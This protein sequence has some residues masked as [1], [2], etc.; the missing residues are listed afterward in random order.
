MISHDEGFAVLRER[1]A[2]A[3]S[4]WGDEA[5]ARAVA[6][7]AHPAEAGGTDLPVLAWLDD[8]LARAAEAV[9][10]DLAGALGAVARSV[11]WQQ[12]AS[13]VE[14]PP[15]ASFLDRYGHAAVAGSDDLTLGL[16]LLGPDVHYPRHHHP[17]E[18]FYLPAGTI[19]WTHAT[20][21]APVREPAGVLL[22]HA[23]WQPH[24]LLTDERPVLLAWVWT[25]EVGT[26]SAF[27]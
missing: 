24:A 22:H 25:G 1:L 15:D 19:R 17:A 8:A 27:C 2:G 13:Y 5:T 18:E 3:V 9:D 16:L 6:R 23:P 26:P 7:L 12:T 4:A 20:D 11:R 10:A 21:D 14:H